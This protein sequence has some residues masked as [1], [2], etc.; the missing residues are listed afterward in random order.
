MLTADQIEHY[1]EEGYV[2]VEGLY[3]PEEVKELG[4]DMNRIIETWGEE[5]IGWRGPW[6]D[7]YLPEDERLNTK[8]CARVPGVE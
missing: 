1:R 6:R 7:R 4:D 5:V 3:T 2:K 8:A